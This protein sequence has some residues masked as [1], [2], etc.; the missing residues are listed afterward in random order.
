MFAQS[1]VNRSVVRCIV[2]TD[3]QDMR[4]ASAALSSA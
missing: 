1:G 2:V 4:L 3:D